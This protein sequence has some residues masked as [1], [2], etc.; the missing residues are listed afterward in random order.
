MVREIIGQIIGIL[1]TVM[2]VISFQTNSKKSLTIVQ[3]TAVICI[4]VSYLFLKAWSGLALNLVV[5]IRNITFY[6]QTPRTKKIYILAGVFSV[7][8]IIL[9]IFSWQGMASVL[10][11]VALTA[12]TIVFSLGDPQIL[13]ISIL[14][15]SPL[16]LLY[17][18]FVFSLGGI[19]CE[20]FG[21]IS[22]VVGIVRFK[23]TQKN[24]KKEAA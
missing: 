5:V 13:R 1:A 6:F 23:Q 2:F 19:A 17:T 20:A 24:G 18:I 15:T 11:M 3:T 14:F 22:S 7:M 16:A 4:C 8:L 10:L 21:I 9:G 12:N